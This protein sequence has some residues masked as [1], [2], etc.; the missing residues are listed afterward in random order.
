MT[1]INLNFGDIPEG[2]GYVQIPE[3][4][5][6]LKIIKCEYRPSRLSKDGSRTVDPGINMEFVPNVAPNTPLYDKRVYG[7]VGFGAKS[8]WKAKE[9]FE[10]LYQR[11]F[12]EN[13][14]QL[15]TD[16]IVGRTVVGVIKH[17]ANEYMNKVGVMVEGVNNRIDKF[18]PDTS[19]PV[20]PGIQ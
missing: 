17:E 2:G 7:Y 19:A 8:M 6:A 16:D 5:L 11:P 4:P 10:A 15:D 13:N 14:V 9:F 18:Q 20:G 12:D 3:G 1:S